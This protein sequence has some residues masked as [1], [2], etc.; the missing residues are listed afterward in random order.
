MNFFKTLALAALFASALSF[1]RPASAQEKRAAAGDSKAPAAAAERRRLAVEVVG[2][3]GGRDHFVASSDIKDDSYTAEIS[4]PRRIN[5]WTRPDGEPPL[6]RIRLRLSEVELE[7]EHAVV[8]EVVAVLDDSWP[9]DAPGPKYGPR[10]KAVG[11][12]LAREGETVSVAGLKSFG[13]EPLVLAVSEAKPEPEMPFIPAPARAVSRVKSIEVVS[14][15]TEGA[16]MERARLVLR[17]VSAK[18]VVGLEM[19]GVDGGVNMIQTFGPR[20]LIA[21]GATYESETSLGRSGRALPGGG[22]EP[23]AQPEALVVST[24]VF[25]DGTYE[26]DAK[27]ASTMLARQA[28]RTIQFARVVKLLQDALGADKPDAPNALAR[29]KSQIDGLRIDVEPS[30]LDELVSRFPSIPRDECRRYVAEWAVDGMR[31]ARAESLGLLERVEAAQSQKAEGFDLRRQ[32]DGV[33][34]AL[35]KKVDARRD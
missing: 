13:F 16:E 27:A 14:F 32:L 30:A 19:G 5:G 35:E 25:D 8:I 29:L 20:P 9:P 7:V 26:G 22:Y 24:A 28:G 11:T 21:S 4:P 1:S 12:Y 18:N 33:R 34:A 3:D 23:V 15:A 6:T 31:M 17:N 2:A 10:E